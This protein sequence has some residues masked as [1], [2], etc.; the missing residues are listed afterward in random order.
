MDNAPAFRIAHS[1][2]T[3]ARQAAREF[4]A[5]VSQPDM[6]LVIFF[7]SNEYDLDALADEL[8]HL[9]GDT[10]LIGCTSAGEFGPG[11]YCGHSLSGVS[12]PAAACT[13]ACER[14]PLLK[15]FTP[16]QGQVFAQ[17]LLQ[18]LERAAPSTAPGNTFAFLLIDGLSV[19][20]EPVVHALHAALGDIPLCGG[21][22]SDGF[23]FSRTWIF[24]EGRF[25]S[26]A[27]LL[28]LVSTPLPFRIF[29]TQHFVAGNERLVVTAAD[30]GRRT[31]YEINGRPAADEY[32]RVLGL[33]VGELKPRVFS[34]N[35]IVILINGTHYVRSI[36]QVAADGSM[37]FYCAIEEGLVLRVA[38]GSDLVAN[39][40]QAFTH[41]REEIGP[42]QLTLGCD[43]ILRQL[44]ITESRLTGQVGALLNENRTVGFNTYGEQYGGVHVNQTFTG[45]SIGRS[46]LP[47]EPDA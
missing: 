1:L 42:P 3:E 21:S 37:I 14:L 11:G 34:H 24:H 29:M 47:P 44:E 27:A 36:Q 17:N 40:A 28:L 31:V 22:A 18:G 15:A 19:R 30:A 13:I 2:A 20:E 9:F 12:F 5:G 46:I 35:P 38:R 45:I 33:T 41:I 8:N 25:H 16:A 4:H 10:P 39:L 26:D 43:C 23:A 32:A 6:A 7:C